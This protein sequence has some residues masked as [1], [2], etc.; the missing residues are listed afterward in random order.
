MKFLGYICWYRIHNQQ[1]T[2]K[3]EKGSTH[4]E[5]EKEESSYSRSKK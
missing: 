4:V 1:E 3:I 5:E 2:L